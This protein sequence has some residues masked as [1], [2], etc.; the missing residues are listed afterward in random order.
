MPLNDDQIC[1]LASMSNDP[2]LGR[3]NCIAIKTAIDE[4]GRLT[5]LLEAVRRRSNYRNGNAADL[6]E[7]YDLV[8]DFDAP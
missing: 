6:R 7:V 2:Q 3:A 5:E 8:I 1:A 4:V